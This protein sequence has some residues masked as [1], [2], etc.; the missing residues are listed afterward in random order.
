LKFG[1]SIALPLDGPTDVRQ[2]ARRTEAAGFD[3]LFLPEH[4]HLASAFLRDHPEV[5]AWHADPDEWARQIGRVADPFVTLA[6]AASVTERLRIGTG[7]CLI[8]QHEPI[9]LAKQVATLDVVS[10]G[11]FLFGIGAG[12]IAGETV[13][14]GIAFASR[15]AAMRERVLAMKALWTGEEVSFAGDTV[16]FDGARQT[17]RPA[18]DPHPPIMVGG[19]S[20]RARAAASEYGDAWMPIHAPG[21]YERI[22][23][24]PTTVVFTTAPDAASLDRYAEA[25]VERCVFDAGTGDPATLRRLAAV[26]ERHAHPSR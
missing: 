22:G 9:V 14:H 21:L 6:V 18:Q 26:A 16:R 25:G 20:A 12:W 3:S 13:N 7:I 8:A 2:V 15:F 11:R 1:I 5:L 23:I 4:T 10:G 19:T 24:V 17:L